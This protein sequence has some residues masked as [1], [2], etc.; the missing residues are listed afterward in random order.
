MRSLGNGVSALITERQRLASGQPPHIVISAGGVTHIF[1]NG[2]SNA[3]LPAIAVFDDAFV[4]QNVCSGIEVDAE[5]R[6]N[7]HELILGAEGVMRNAALQEHVRRIEEQNRTIRDRSQALP[8]AIR[9]D[10]SVDA[11]C[12]L[13][14]NPNLALDIRMA[15]RN[16]ATARSSDTIIRQAIFIPPAI[17]TFDIE[18][19]SGILARDL[20]A[21]EAEASLRVQAHLE[22]IGDRG[23][24]WIA[25]GMGRI[26][27]ASEGF[28]N[29]ICPFC[30]QDLAGSSVI[31]HYQAYF[32]EAYANL[33][34]A[35]ADII[36]AVSRAHS[37]DVPQRL[38]VRS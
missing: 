6:H 5:H 9:G 15:E 19:I 36:R 25:D 1:Q 22:K 20:P 11:F 38:S 18:A 34:A 14:N 24:A 28:D 7:L 37:G 12:A 33:K 23:D 3:I 35:I 2:A 21:M 10:L 27:G 26:A 13:E 4:S 31:G 29:Q 8:T 16:L 17:P 32:S 30:T